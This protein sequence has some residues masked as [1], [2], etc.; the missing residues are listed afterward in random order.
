M[1]WFR[2]KEESE[3]QVNVETTANHLQRKS[4][5]GKSRILRVELIGIP[6]ARDRGRSG[7]NID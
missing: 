5:T 3:K 4:T 2:P 7:D 1:Q 6:A